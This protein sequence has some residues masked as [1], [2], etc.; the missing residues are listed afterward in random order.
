MNLTKNEINLM[1]K[2]PAKFVGRDKRTAEELVGKG[3]FCATSK[4]QFE[5]TEEGQ[6][7]L[8]ARAPRKGT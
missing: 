6:K 3:A 4:D 5:L 7:E 1:R 2:P 8:D